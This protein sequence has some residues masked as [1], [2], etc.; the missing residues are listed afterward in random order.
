M[1]PFDRAVRA[2]VYRLLADG[3]GQVDA[4]ALGRS[5]GWDPRQVAA[6]LERLEAQHRIALLPGTHR[7]WMAHPFSG[8]D[9]GYRAHIGTRSWPANCAWDALAIVALLGDGAGRATGRGGHID[10]NIEDGLVSPDGLVHL[11]VPAA[12]FWDDIGFT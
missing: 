1:T 2:E 11:L 10:W 8:I 9:T 4:T 7:V 3:V 12:R 6:S 5:G